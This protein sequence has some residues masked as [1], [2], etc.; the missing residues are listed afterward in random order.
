MIIRL[1]YIIQAPH[2]RY[3][4]HPVGCV[5]QSEVSALVAG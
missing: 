3:S 2:T 4:D 1:I 5:D